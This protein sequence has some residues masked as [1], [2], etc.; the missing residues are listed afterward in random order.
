MEEDSAGTT[1]GGRDDTGTGTGTGTAADA[2]ADAVVANDVAELV[3][4]PAAPAATIAVV[5]VAA[6]VV[7]VLIGSAPKT[8][9]RTGFEVVA[10]AVAVADG[11]A[12]AVAEAAANSSPD[13]CRRI[14]GV[15]KPL[16]DSCSNEL[17]EEEVR[18]GVRRS[19]CLRSKAGRGVP[20]GEKSWL[21]I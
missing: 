17:V 3:E 15:V 16:S 19:E 10:A 14:G 1:I 13:R 21:G 7:D 20:R 6:A 2:D 9:D 5:V 8:S 18:D 12:V 4:S 11:V